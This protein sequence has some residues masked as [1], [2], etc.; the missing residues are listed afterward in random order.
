MWQV[1]NRT[2]FAAAQSWVRNLDG[3]ETWIVVVKATFDVLEDGSTR[4]A[5][6]QPK[7]V[8]TPVYRGEPGRS[9]IEYESDFALGKTTTDIVVNGSAFAPGGRPATAVDV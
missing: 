9:S 2:P 1:D 3:A 8:R 6:E 4:V 7:P 5:A